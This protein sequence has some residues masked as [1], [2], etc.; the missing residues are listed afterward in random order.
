MRVKSGRRRM[1]DRSLA[2]LKEGRVGAIGKDYL[3]YR[4]R[5]LRSLCMV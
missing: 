1:Y 2:G 4:F 5:H 3:D